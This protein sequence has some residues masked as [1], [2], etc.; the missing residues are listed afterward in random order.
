M[1]VEACSDD[2]EVSSNDNAERYIRSNGIEGMFSEWQ[3]RY[4][5]MGKKI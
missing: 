2:N 1:A 4:D 3:L 5:L